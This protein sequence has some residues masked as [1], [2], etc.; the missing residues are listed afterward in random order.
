MAF[1]EIFNPGSA[2]LKEQRAAEK[3]LPPSL[4]VPA[5]LWDDPESAFV[6]PDPVTFKPFRAADDEDDDSEPSEDR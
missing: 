4:S 2:Y 6:I 5:P 3:L 1:E